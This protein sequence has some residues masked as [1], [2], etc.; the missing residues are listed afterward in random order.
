MREAR[1][2]AKQI[3]IRQVAQESGVSSATVSYVLNGKKR[4]SPETKARVL[5]AVERLDYVPNINARSLSTRNSF[6]IGVLIPQTEPGNHLMFENPFYSEMLSAIEYEARIHGYRLLVAGVDIG[7]PYLNMAR[8]RNLDGIIAIGVYQDTFYRQVVQS[9]IPLVLVD[10]YSD[11]TRC[12]NIRI[13]DTDGAYLALHYLLD[14]GHRDI[15]FFCGSLRDNGV[16]KKRLDGYRRALEE[17]G[18]PYDKEKII[19][20]NVDFEN[21]IILAR[22]LLE[23]KLPASAVFA[24]ADILAIGAMKAFYDAGLRVPHDISIMGFDDI[25]FSRYICPGLTTVRQDISLKSK[26]AI[27]LL[28]ENIKNP[29]LTKREEI[30]PVSIVER[31]SVRALSGKEEKMIYSSA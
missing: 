18:I 16:M 17:R 24:A 19:E 4:I 27:E 10:S 6:L 25:K 20:G 26:R 15:A 9:G 21:G 28:V 1:Q 22:R 13:D 23:A 12:H 7:K 5:A 30:L 3:T 11:D 29:H 31:G 8:E 14:R 2:T